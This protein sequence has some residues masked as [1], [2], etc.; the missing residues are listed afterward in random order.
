MLLSHATLGCTASNH[1]VPGTKKMTVC[2]CIAVKAGKTAGS[3]ATCRPSQ[4]QGSCSL[5][6][7]NNSVTCLQE[8]CQHS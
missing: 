1:L 6:C 2:I 3:K 5:A 4:S 7:H 8:T